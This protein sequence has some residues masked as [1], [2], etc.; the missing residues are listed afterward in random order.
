MREIERIRESVE[1]G[2]IPAVYLWYGEERFLIQK[3]LQILKSFYFKMDP[4]GIGIEAVSA[5]DLS[6]LDIV[7]RANTMSFITNRLLIVEEVNYFQDGQ[8]SDIEP[9]IDYMANPNPSTCLLLITERVHKGRKL[10][11]T[12]DKAGEILEFTAPKRA[13]DWNVW[14]QDELKARGKT[15][16]TQ[17]VSFFIDWAGHNVGVLSQELE[18]LETYVGDRKKIMAEDIKIITTRTVESTVF[19]LLDAVAGRNSAKALQA[20]HEVLRQEHPLKV[21][22]MLV[23]QARLLLGCD[24]LRRRGGNASEVSS[25]LGISPFEAQKVWLQSGRLS[26]EQLTKAMTECLNTDVA[27]KTGG[28]D[29]GF[30]LEMM[31]I[32]FCVR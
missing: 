22:T 25:A 7:D 2:K 32:K 17:V 4:S 20:L 8:T 6:P 12:I 10:Y 30:L 29:P 9:L 24:A 16:D 26:T 13:Q 1:S 15:M 31:V 19:D 14:V 23:R 27:L 28:G 5:K 11:K 3:A 18:K 21:L